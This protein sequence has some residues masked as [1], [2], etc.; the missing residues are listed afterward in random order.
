MCSLFDFSEVDLVGGV[1]G[2]SLHGHK[3]EEAHDQEEDEHQTNAD[4]GQGVR[5]QVVLDNS[6]IANLSNTLWEG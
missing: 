3:L 4:A 1:V 2:G 5:E 6:V